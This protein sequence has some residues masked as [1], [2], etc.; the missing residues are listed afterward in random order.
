[1]QVGDLVKYKSCGTHGIITKVYESHK[2]SWDDYMFEVI[3]IDGVTSD[4]PKRHIE[5][6]A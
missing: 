2:H 5:V 4:V 6:V 3:W 1:M